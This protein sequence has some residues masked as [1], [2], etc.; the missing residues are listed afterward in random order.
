MWFQQPIG[1]CIN[2]NAIGVFVKSCCKLT[3]KVDK[4]TTPLYYSSFI[5]S[6]HWDVLSQA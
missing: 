5:I 3:K 4:N 6:F 2:F 1:E